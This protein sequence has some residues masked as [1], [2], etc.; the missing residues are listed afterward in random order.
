MVRKFSGRDF[1]NIIVDAGNDN[2]NVNVVKHVLLP[3][4][5][6]QLR[7]YGKISQRSVRERIQVEFVIVSRSLSQRADESYLSSRHQHRASQI[8][9]AASGIQTRCSDHG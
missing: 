9:S 3:T 7:T 4:D 8:V 6:F 1:K 5:G 2:I